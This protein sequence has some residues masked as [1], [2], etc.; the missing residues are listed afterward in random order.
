MLRFSFRQWVLLVLGCIL[1]LLSVSLNRLAG[2]WEEVSGDDPVIW[3]RLTID[4]GRHARI[5]SLGESNLVV[6]STSNAEARMTLFIREDRASGPAELVKDLCGRDSCVYRPLNDER[7]DGA[8]AD[9]ASGTPFRIILMHVHDSQV[10]LEYKGPE[11]E[12]TTFDTLIDAI[13]TQTQAT[14]QDES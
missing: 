2:L 3:N 4:T 10:W 1:I 13:I 8:I 5:S 11:D 12:F 9:Y 7:L 14:R 6:R